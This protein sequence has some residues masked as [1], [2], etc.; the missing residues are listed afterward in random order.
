E[1]PVSAMPVDGT[2]PSATAAWEKRNIS[3]V[4]PVWEPD[5]CIQCGQCS[6]VCPHSVILA[7]YYDEQ[8]LQSAPASFKSAPVNARGYPGA[9][10]TLEL[11]IEDCT[12]CELCVQACPAR[13][14]LEPAL[15]AINMAPK[16][17]M[18]KTEQE[19]LEFFEQL[20][21]NDRSR[22][23]FAN[24]RGVQFLEPLFEFSGACAGC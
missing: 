20:P 2:F 10:Y 8:A 9:R 4:V 16:A 13:S 1:I 22:V 7:K 12:G 11:S 3:D 24:V 21:V 15:K 6:I 5:L 18:L 23:D 14:A 17:P 19:N